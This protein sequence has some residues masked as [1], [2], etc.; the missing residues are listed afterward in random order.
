MSVF[1]TGVYDPKSNQWCTVTKVGNGF[2]DSTLDKLQTELSMVK[3]SKKADKVPDWLNVKKNLIPDFVV[4]DPKKAPVWE[5]SGAEF[6]KA[7]VSRELV[8]RCQVPNYNY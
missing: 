7:E 6:S 4:A 1:L 2:D 5:I 8:Y 3:I